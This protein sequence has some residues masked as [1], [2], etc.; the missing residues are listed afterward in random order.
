ML[1]DEELFKRYG[2]LKYFLEFNWG[3]V[4]LKLQRVKKPGDVRSAIRLVPR[5]ETLPVFRDYNAFCFVN[6]G[7]GPV[8]F[9]V[10]RDTRRKHEEAVATL[11]SCWSDFHTS[12]QKLSSAQN[13]LKI[14][15]WELAPL[16]CFLSVFAYLVAMDVDVQKVAREFEAA[17]RALTNA[18][19]LEESLH[20]K[21]A[22]QEAWFAQ[23]EI[24]K[25]KRSKRHSLENPDDLAKAMA[26]MPEYG[27][28]NSFRRC[29][30]LNIESFSPSLVLRS[31][32]YPYQLFEMVGRITERMKPLKVARVE[33]RLVDELRSK[34]NTL[35]RE[36]VK[37][38]WLHM[39]RAFGDCAGKRLTRHTLPYFLIGRFI[40]R[41]ESGTSAYDGELANLA[42]TKLTPLAP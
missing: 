30:N 33:K 9:S 7:R 40:D 1:E 20:K 34:E 14:A 27:W 28:F 23:N 4:G 3:R 13:S 21:R 35:L 18:K 38:H 6:E 8:H 11:N 29:K 17:Q 37:M 26:G 32:A 22:S 15:V 42:E 10:V 16:A 25:L 24:V 31:S 2:A 5:F 36:T 41:M 12:S 39:E 19:S